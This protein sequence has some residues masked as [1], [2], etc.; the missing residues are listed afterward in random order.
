MA[1]A[2][3]TGGGPGV[4]LLEA[5]LDAIHKV[6]DRIGGRAVSKL[7]AQLDVAETTTLAVLSTI[8]FGEY[9]DGAGDAR[10]LVGD[11]IVLATGRTTD[12]PYTFTGLTRGAEGTEARTWPPGTLVY[13]YAENTSA[14]DLLRRGFFVDTAVS[15]DLRILARNLGLKVCPGI[16]T[17]ELRRVIRAIAYLPK[18]PV[19]AVRKVLEAYYGDT[20]SWAVYERHESAPWTIF[21]EVDVT[22]RTDIRG[23]FFLNGGELQETTG[24]LT[25]DTAYPINHVI[26]VYDD[27][28]LTRRGY[29]DGLTNY[30][31]SGSFLG[32]TI[33][34]GSSPGGAGTPVIVDYGAFE[35]HYLAADETVRQDSENADHWAYL[36]DPFVTLRCLLEQ[37]RA[38]GYKI[39]IVART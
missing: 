38:A 5:T 33:T 16:S 32:S 6:D 7:T 11:E 23:R 1:D 12:D 24:A 2:P 20:A 8:G 36:G 13:D 4:G 39:E 10:L 3:G 34:L 35:A 37:V 9:V 30:F 31:T 17:E 18:G 25:V 21:V 26:G 28:L 19:D 29:R 22:L 14:I 27:T 15:E